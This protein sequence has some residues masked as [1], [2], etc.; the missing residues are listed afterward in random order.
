[1]S[2]EVFERVQARLSG[3]RRRTTPLHNGGGFILSK[4]LVCGHCGGYLSGVM[5][6]GKR[7]YIC[8]NYITH[9]RGHCNRN[10]V[11]EQ[12]IL[13]VLLRELQTAF[14]RPRQPAAPA[15]RGEGD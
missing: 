4:L 9:G 3:N 1:V 13:D 6:Q 15:R 10:T 5:G 2:R 14:L 7:S 11:A 12:V 8:T